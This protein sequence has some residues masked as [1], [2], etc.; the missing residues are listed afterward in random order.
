VV[1][2]VGEERMAKRKSNKKSKPVKTCCP[3]PSERKTVSIRK[4]I[5]GFIVNMD[6]STKS[7]FIEKTMIA[8]TKKEAKEMASKLL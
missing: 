8:K 3:T 6:K 5:N 4:A 7:G 2:D 1:K